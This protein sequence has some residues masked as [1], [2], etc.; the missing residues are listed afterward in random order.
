M[1]LTQTTRLHPAL[2][3]S[4]TYFLPAVP[5]TC[6]PL[7]FLTISFPGVFW[8]P[9][10]KKR[11]RKFIVNTLSAL[12]LNRSIPHNQQAATQDST[13]STGTQARYNDWI[14]KGKKL[15][16]AV[17]IGCNQPHEAYNPVGIHQ[18]APP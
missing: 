10:R 16:H 14:S 13:T 9:S 4:S 7:P 17:L 18:M 1:S 3:C 6:S 11:R 12:Q 5:E 8:L 15:P 2:S